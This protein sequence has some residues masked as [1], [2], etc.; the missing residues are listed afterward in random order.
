MLTCRPLSL[1]RHMTSIVFLFWVCCPFWLY[2]DRDMSHPR[3]EF[4]LVSSWMHP[5][6]FSLVVCFWM[7]PSSS[8]SSVF[9]SSSS[10]M[11]YFSSC[12]PPFVFIYCTLIFHCGKKLCHP[13]WFF[14]FATIRRN[15][16]TCCFA[17]L[18]GYSQR[19]QRATQCRIC[20][21]PVMSVGGC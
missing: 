12:S 7:Q 17:L 16:L 5:L 19:L 2:I 9:W 18:L 13:K 14:L 6:N 10:S 1:Q 21:N 15:W 8:M 4:S 3:Q 20:I 11:K